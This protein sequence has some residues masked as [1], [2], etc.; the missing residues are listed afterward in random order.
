MRNK[1]GFQISVVAFLLLTMAGTSATAEKLMTA[2][3]A[4]KRVYEYTGFDELKDMSAEKA[5]S[6]CRRI[7]IIEDDTPFLYKEVIGRDVWEVRLDDIKLTMADWDENLQR[8]HNGK[9]LIALVDI[10]TGVLYRVYS[11][12]EYEDPDLAPE[13]PAESATV[14]Q[15]LSRK[16]YTGFPQEPPAVSLREALNAACGSNPLEAKEIIAV[17]VLFSHQGAEPVPV[18]A[19]T[20][21]GIPASELAGD[22]DVPVYLRNRARTI[23]NA[24]D[25]KAWIVTNT[26]R[27]LLKPEDRK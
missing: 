4:V 20:G 16:V 8:S 15:T 21:R 23:V 25:G 5:G 11:S 2:E 27:V 17:C 19:I 26:P 13:P 7:T 9:D 6:A 10:E 3:Q 12:L 24:V 14:W 22:E 18:W 1:L